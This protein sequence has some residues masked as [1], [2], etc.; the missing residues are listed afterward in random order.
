MLECD[1]RRSS[2]APYRLEVDR[3]CSAS[4]FDCGCR[5]FDELAVHLDGRRLRDY[6]AAVRSPIRSVSCASQLLREDGSLDGR[7]SAE[8]VCFKMR[9]HAYVIEVR[10][11]QRWKQ[12]PL[13]IGHGGHGY[14]LR[15]EQAATVS[16]VK[17][18]GFE[19][20]LVQ[21]RRQVVGKLWHS[22]CSNISQII[23]LRTTGA[24]RIAGGST[25][26]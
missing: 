20:L 2:K 12:S 5:D 8:R 14:A 15:I 22:V 23:R 18:S 10:L 24:I 16:I 21:S 25:Q 7:D 6:I 17:L 11:E 3:Q 4:V 9:L 13:G 1:T 19:R 26:R